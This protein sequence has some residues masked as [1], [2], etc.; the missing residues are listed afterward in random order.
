MP[1]GSQYNLRSQESQQ[2]VQDDTDEDGNAAQP[3]HM[4]AIIA[5]LNALTNAVAQLKAIT[6]ES[7][8]D[9]E[10]L[11][12]NIQFD[13]RSNVIEAMQQDSETTPVTRPERSTQN[14]V[15]EVSDSV[16]KLYDLPIFSGNTEDWPLFLANYKDTTETFRYSNRHNLMRLHKCLVGRARETVA[17]MLIYPD[18]VPNAIAELE[19]QFGR[20]D[21]L[22]RSQLLKI[23]QFQTIAENKVEQI[24]AFSTRTRNVVAFL[25]SAKCEHHLANTTLLEQLVTKL[26]PSKQFEWTRYAVNLK[27]Y[28]N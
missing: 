1:G 19:F 3:A 2:G 10:R 9:I 18:D 20:P 11:R 6:E 17:S 21:L 23:Q 5:S 4:T 12:N 24:L 7:Q 14:A 16:T 8:R 28:H 22:V 13:A 26:P 27:P 15:L 25:T